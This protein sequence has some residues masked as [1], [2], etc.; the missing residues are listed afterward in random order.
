[1]S[2]SIGGIVLKIRAAPGAMET[3]FLMEAAELAF[4]E[5]RKV[6]ALF[7]GKEYVIDPFEI[8]NSFPFA[9]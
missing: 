2:S 1:M 5:S 6:V 9:K 8:I 7:N 4:K 3:S